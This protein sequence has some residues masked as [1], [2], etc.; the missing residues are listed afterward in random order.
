MSLHESSNE[1]LAAGL[2]AGATGLAAGLANSVNPLMTAA[3]LPATLFYS[4]K[5]G[6]VHTAPID[7]ALLI[8][9]AVASAATMFATDNPLI[10]GA[11]VLTQ[12]LVQGGYAYLTTDKSASPDV[13]N[14]T[15]KQL[16]DAQP[17]PATLEE[18]L[19]RAEGIVHSLMKPE[20]LTGTHAFTDFRHE[21]PA[22]RKLVEG[23]LGHPFPGRLYTY[24]EKF[25]G[26][27]GISC[28]ADLALSHELLASGS[29]AKQLFVAGHEMSH[30]NHGDL[31]LGT[32]INELAD[33]TP[34]LK[35]PAVL[36]A[37]RPLA[38]AQELR[39]DLEGADFAVQHGVPAA[40][41]L[42]VARELNGKCE[43]SDSHPSSDRRLQALSQHLK[44]S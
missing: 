9:G 16:Y 23:W 7:R 21:D 44:V 18:S 36:K 35:A 41:V 5:V 42:A 6:R 20:H 11:V 39:A 22:A 1:R 30:L 40:E 38:H 31:S 15:F 37:Q 24:N 13:D 14:A 19:Q 17:A 28:G 33:M 34:T 25:L 32:A 12:A 4:S 43:D 3:A 10:R 26:T 8:G 2:K 27:P 29:L